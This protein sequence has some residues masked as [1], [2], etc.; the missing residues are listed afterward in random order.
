MAKPTT[1]RI[2]DDLLKEIDQFVKKMRVDRSVYLR[3]VLRK[4]FSLDKQERVLSHYAQA[5]LSLLEACKELK[6]NPWEFLAMLHSRN[7]HLNVALEDWLDS[8]DLEI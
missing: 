7:L 2:P 5:E 3:E 8:K 6:C 4:G 1:V